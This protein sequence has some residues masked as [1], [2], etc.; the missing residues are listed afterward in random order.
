V[1]FE[2][3][4][5]TPVS[6][7]A[8]D[9]FV[10]WVPADTPYK[11][12]MDYVAAVKAEPGKFKMGGTGAKQEDQIVTAAIEGKT[13]AKFTYIP[14]GGGG[15]V[16]GQLIA[17]KID[18]TVNNPIEAVDGW[19]AGKLHPLCVFAAKRMAYPEKIT[20]NHSWQDI[21]TCKEAGLDVQYLMLR[22]IFMPPAVEPEAVDWYI[23][24]FKKIRATPDW[25]AFMKEGAYDTTFMAG[26]EFKKWLTEAATLHHDLMD[27]AGF[28]GQR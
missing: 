26:D 20:A 15:S 17:K 12:A 2:W 23:D 7:L 21:P 24:L 19:R 5:F 8:L 11:T 9:E 16:A 27:R 1:P 10:L 22:G 6:M 13:G 25:Q 28:L 4:D 14:L 18:S 3:T